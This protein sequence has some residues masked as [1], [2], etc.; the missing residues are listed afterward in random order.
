MTSQFYFTADNLKSLICAVIE[1][2]IDDLRNDDYSIKI[3][4]IDDAMA[5]ILTLQCEEYCLDVG[6]PYE[7]VRQK[8]VDLY[9]RHLD[10]VIPEL[11]SSFNRKYA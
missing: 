5:F 9:R 10:S 11:K 8:A 4:D 7:A 6:V 3:R 1:R 2:S